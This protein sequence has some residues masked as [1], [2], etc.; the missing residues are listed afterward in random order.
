M[1][2]TLCIIFAAAG[3]A[4]GATEIPVTWDSSIGWFPEGA[5][6]TDSSSI[7]VLLP[8]NLREMDAVG[9]PGPIFSWSSENYE[10]SGEIYVDPTFG[11]LSVKEGYSRTEA[12]L[13]LPVERYSPASGYEQS[14]LGYT[15]TPGGNITLSLVNV[16]SDGSF[17]A[18]QQWSTTSALPG[19]AARRR[20]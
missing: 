16:L 4:M 2:K 1:K 12:E 14:L 13:S 3:I 8:L 15:F 6:S 7:S 18:L 11:E 19:L 5:P 9:G 10:Y 17:E 20:R